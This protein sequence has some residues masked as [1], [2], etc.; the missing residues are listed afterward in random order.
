MVNWK[1][2]TRTMT[3]GNLRPKG[4]T[5]I[6]MM[7][8]LGIIGLGLMV[9][10]PRYS[11]PRGQDPVV[12][13]LE[14]QRNKAYNSGQPQFITLSQGALVNQN[15]GARFPFLS[16]DKVGLLYPPPSPYLEGHLFTYLYPSG[17][18]T[19]GALEIKNRGKKRIL[20]IHPLRGTVHVVP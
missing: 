18:A 5:L 13:F 1:R 8:V 7:I 10:L 15:D 11:P 19:A 9:M 17:T 16:S 2:K 6:E 4:F 14:E 3:R 20:Y 12:F